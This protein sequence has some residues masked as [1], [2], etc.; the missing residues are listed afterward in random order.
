[1]RIRVGYQ[2]TYTPRDACYTTLNIHYSRVSDI[3]P[4]YLTSDPAV[5]TSPATGMASATG[6]TGLWRR[7]AGF[8]RDPGG[9][10]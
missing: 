8:I 1:M 3:E 4:D 7:W 9:W 2:L 10:G 5:P 6:A